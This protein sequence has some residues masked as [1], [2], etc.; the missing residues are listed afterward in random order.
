VWFA[1]DS[2]QGTLLVKIEAKKKARLEVTTA[3]KRL[4]RI[5]QLCSKFKLEENETELFHVMAILQGSNER[6]VLDSLLDEDTARRV[7]G[8]QRLTGNSEA[9]I[10]RFC[11]DTRPH[12]KEGLVLVDESNGVHFSIRIPRTA[13]YLFY[14][15]H[16][17]SDDL[18]KVAQT[19][20]EDI[21]KE[22][23]SFEAIRSHGRDSGSKVAEADSTHTSR[24]A[25]KHSIPDCDS[26]IP[27]T[28][29]S[30]LEDRSVSPDNRSRKMKSVDLRHS[31][32]RLDSLL[33][34]GLECQTSAV[35][36]GADLSSANE[37]P[38]DAIPERVQSSKANM[39]YSLDDQLEFLEDCFQVVGLMIRASA[40]R[41]KDDMKKEGMSAWETGGEVKH[42]RR[43]LHAKLRVHEARVS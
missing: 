22:E 41:M 40:A 43:E 32:S 1:N 12:I 9:D 38:P 19:T 25:R 5:L 28:L 11:D 7:V 34:N 2:A 29:S 6:A 35:E 39:P 8:Y 15:R 31:D 10:Q 30:S 13:A 24:I 37:T 23:G 16:I 21:L 33:G 26:P 42:G 20:L 17:D 18:L 3:A 36:D 27:C 4:P 14:G